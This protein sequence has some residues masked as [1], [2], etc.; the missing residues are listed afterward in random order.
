[1]IL[2]NA[3]MCIIMIVIICIISRRTLFIFQRQ[4]RP[5]SSLCLEVGRFVSYLF[6][7]PLGAYTY[8]YIYIY[9][10]IYIYTSP[11]PLSPPFLLCFASFLL[12]SCAPLL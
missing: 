3:I 1:M 11:S 9:I 2:I 12:G 8:I 5:P 10:C 6:P 4:L 7:F